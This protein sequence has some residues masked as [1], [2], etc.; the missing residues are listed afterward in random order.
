M[1]LNIISYTHTHTHT[2]HMGKGLVYNLSAC[3]SLWKRWS[4]SDLH[5]LI[6]C[7]QQHIPTHV[8]TVKFNVFVNRTPNLGWTHEDW[9]HQKN[10][11]AKQTWREQHFAAVF[12]KLLFTAALHLSSKEL[13]IPLRWT[14]SL[15][16]CSISKLDFWESSKPALQN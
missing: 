1:R 16:L 9:S 4:T 10:W 7:T 14:Q 8:H 2:G 15:P 12:K 5:T 3:M 6:S 13:Q 11:N